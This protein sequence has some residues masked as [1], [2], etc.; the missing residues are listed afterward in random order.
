MANGK[1]NKESKL[2]M[3]AAVVTIRSKSFVYTLT[4]TEFFL[5]SPFVILNLYQ[6]L[7]YS[8]DLKTVDKVVYRRE[9]SS[10]QAKVGHAE[11]PTGPV[12]VL[13]CCN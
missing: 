11:N 8:L 12:P 1:S 13:N 2:R 4:C 9:N 10:V 5:T 7:T 3:K 6:H